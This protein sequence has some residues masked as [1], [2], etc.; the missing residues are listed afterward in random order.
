MRALAATPPVCWRSPPRGAR[1]QRSIPRRRLLACDRSSLRDE[2]PWQV[3]R[4]P[5]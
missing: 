4:P 3:C 5:A 2:A 1:G